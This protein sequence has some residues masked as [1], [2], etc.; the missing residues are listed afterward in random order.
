MGLFDIFSKEKKEDLNKVLERSNQGFFSKIS[1][2]V[3]GKSKVDDVVLD[4]L[5]EIL[6]SSDVGVQ[7]TVKIIERIEERIAR[8]K[9]VG[10]SELNT[11]L[12]E[13]IVTLLEEN[14]SS[15]QVEFSV[16]ESSGPF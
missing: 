12:K 7:T 5:E 2:A 15:D 4:D 9:Y 1:R 13:E 16:P 11:I 10:T 6:I 8:D 14:Y 3:A